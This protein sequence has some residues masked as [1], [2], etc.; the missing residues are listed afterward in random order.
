MGV[1]EF[2]KRGHLALV[3]L[4]RPEALNALNAEVQAGLRA[5]WTE[6]EADEEVRVAILTGTGRA[7]SAGA[8]LKTMEGRPPAPGVALPG[9]GSAP[10]GST[11]TKPVIAAIHG[12][13]LAGALELAL[14]CDLRI[15]SERAQFGA[16]EVKWNVLHGYGAL[17]LPHLVPMA[18]AMEMMLTGEFIDA[19]RAL[20]IGLVSRVV[21]PEDLLPACEALAAR[22]A[23]NGQ[24]SVRITKRL[25]YA[26]L[27]MGLDQARELSAALGQINRASPD[28]QEG[29]RAFAEKR[30]PRFSAAAGVA[31]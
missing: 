10:S 2:E 8:D 11:V 3:T 15:A 12:Y 16:P 7:F 25:A 4:N 22:I 14:A 29:P 24:L 21:A 1:V 5:A 31:T 19:Q 27:R 6:V 23:S 28:S 18:S 17:R 13:G 20:Q 26:S 9:T 30:V